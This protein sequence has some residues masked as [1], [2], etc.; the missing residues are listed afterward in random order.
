MSGTRAGNKL[1]MTTLFDAHCHLRPNA[2]AN[3]AAPPA[4]ANKVRG[5]LLC[6]V[7]PGDWQAVATLTQT[8]DGTIA[9]FGLHPWHL[10]DA[11]GKDWLAGL[12]SLLTADANA[13]LGEAGLDNRRQ[14]IAAAGEQE[15]AF[16]RQL[17][18][19]ASLQRKINL[20]CVGAWE[21][22][23]SLLDDAYLPSMAGT[24]FIVHGF[25]GPYQFV[26]LLADR[27]AYFSVGRLISAKTSRKM[28]ERAAL[29]PADRILLESDEFLEPGI[30]AVS[31]LT[32]ALSWL[33]SVRNVP[34]HELG[35][36]IAQN[37]QKVFHGG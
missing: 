23:V 28:R 7:G 15:A 19:A 9:A 18:L 5:R 13:W 32:E 37:A 8:W 16:A 3:P 10:A 21:P 29:F 30:D 27:G 26:R 11:A 20:H 1:W 14:G 4:H 2:G 35:E 22:L 33:A 24:P 36:T 6:G 17:R 31:E 12:E 25:G 34:A